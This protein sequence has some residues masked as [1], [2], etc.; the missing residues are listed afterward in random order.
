V[1]IES[2]RVIEAVIVLVQVADIV[3]RDCE[4]EVLVEAV[5]VQVLAMKV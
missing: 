5:R 1:L 4:N 2:V 3:C